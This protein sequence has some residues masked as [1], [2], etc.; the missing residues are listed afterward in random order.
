MQFTT[1]A[2][3]LIA[4]LSFGSAAPSELRDRSPAPVSNLIQ[5]PADHS[6]DMVKRAHLEARCD[7]SC[8]CNWCG[9]TICCE[10]IGTCLEESLAMRHLILPAETGRCMNTIALVGSCWQKLSASTPHPSYLQ[11]HVTPAFTDQA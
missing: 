11:Q 10:C 3:P 5:Y 2:L 7:V 4:L 1:L 6:I 9:M 8:P